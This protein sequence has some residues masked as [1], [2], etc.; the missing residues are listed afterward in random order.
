MLDFPANHVCLPEDTLRVP[1][2][3]IE[4]AM[5]SHQIQ[6]NIL[7][8]PFWF[9]QTNTPTFCLKHVPP[10]FHVYLSPDFPAG[11]EFYHSS[12]WSLFETKACT[13]ARIDKPG[14]KCR[15]NLDLRVLVLVM[16]VS[17]WMLSIDENSWKSE[18]VWMLYFHFQHHGGDWDF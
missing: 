1:W 8:R 4:I 6:G 16:F 13:E 15:W 12:R 10:T 7:K 11:G 18:T 17:G 2:L 14:S 9:S 3:S 5:E